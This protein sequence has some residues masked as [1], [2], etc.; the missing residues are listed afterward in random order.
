MPQFDFSSCSGSHT[1]TRSVCNTLISQVC[2]SGNSLS[3]SPRSICLTQSGAQCCISWSADVGA[4]A[5]SSL[6][7]AAENTANECT[8]NA[9]SGLQRNTPLNGG[10]VT[11][12]LSNRA[13][14]CS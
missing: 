14:G 6:C 13:T 2:N 4:I 5:E 3:S 10:C 12:C 8:G 1:A 7:G 11:Q 9:V